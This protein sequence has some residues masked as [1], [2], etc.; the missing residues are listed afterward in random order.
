M[1]SE[2]AKFRRVPTP[3]SGP[4]LSVINFIYNTRYKNYLL[5][6]A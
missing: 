5:D 1:V 4:K 6:A 3:N 2:A